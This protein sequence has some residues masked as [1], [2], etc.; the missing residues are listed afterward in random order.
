MTCASFSCLAGGGAREADRRR[1]GQ[2]AEAQGGDDGA[3]GRGE[4][5][6]GKEDES[7]TKPGQMPISNLLSPSLSPYLMRVMR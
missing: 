4:T 2:G 5:S 6:A 3:E 7:E 1:A